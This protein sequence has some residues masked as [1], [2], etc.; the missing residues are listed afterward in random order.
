MKK[1]LIAFTI[2]FFIPNFS[3]A[4]QKTIIFSEIAWMGTKISA[5]DEWIELK[6]LTNSEINLE[7]FKIKDKNSNFKINL[8]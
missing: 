4:I 5:Y 1:Y 3:F 2:I 6:N 7:N 8:S